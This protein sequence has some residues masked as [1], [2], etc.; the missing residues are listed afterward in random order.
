MLA[1]LPNELLLE[2]VGRLAYVQ[3]MPQGLLKPAS[4]FQPP[5]PDLLSLSIVSWQI[6]AI[7]L[8][9]LFANIHITTSSDAQKL[10][11]FCSTSPLCPTLTSMLLIRF[12]GNEAEE[13]KGY[14]ILC[15]ILPCLERLSCIDLGDFHCSLA[16]FS[17][18]LGHPS[19]STVLI[20]S[21]S[22]I[23]LPRPLPKDLSKVV[24]VQAMLCPADHQ[25]GLL[26]DECSDRGMKIAKMSIAMS[27]L[28][29]GLS[30]IL[31]IRGL[32]ELVL[33]PRDKP[34]PFSWLPE[35]TATHPHLKKV[36]LHVLD[37]ISFFLD[38]LPFFLVSFAEELGQR[39]IKRGFR[40]GNIGLE[41]EPE[42]LTGECSS[43]HR[44]HVREMEIYGDDYPLLLEIL[45]LVT[46][47]FPGIHTF[48]LSLD[49]SHI[50][51]S[52]T[53]HVDDLVAVLQRFPC[54]QNLELYGLPEALTTGDGE[55][56]LGCLDEMDQPIAIATASGEA[57][58]ISP[59]LLFSYIMK[60]IQTLETIK[61]H[62]RGF[63]STG[64]LYAI[65]GSRTKLAQLKSV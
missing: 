48:S 39:G 65:D 37:D 60:K 59:W 22:M 62:Q 41:L 50:L 55:V 38:P 43:K 12:R 42:R 26:L 32:Q 10:L 64:W 1:L 31:T 21:N 49:H 44:W 46:S 54:L 29:D 35:F 9:F 16:I 58:S 63:G 17:T 2:I 36:W 23:D 11:E 7:S 51:R 19:L 34:V 20:S 33:Y 45:P 25:Y 8:A 52:F 18:I 40:I 56:S 30:G 13:V 53:L 27:Q 4:T 61:I 15:Q 14:A 47:A 5:S 3:Q 24:L 6:R 28:L 57:S